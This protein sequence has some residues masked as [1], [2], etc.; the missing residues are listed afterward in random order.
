MRE[1]LKDKITNDLMETYKASDVRDALVRM[2]MDTYDFMAGKI[3]AKFP[4]PS[5]MD[6]IRAHTCNLGKAYG[7][8]GVILFVSAASCG[9]G[10][11]ASDCMEYI[12]KDGTFRPEDV[13][14]VVTDMFKY[15]AGSIRCPDAEISS[16]P[17]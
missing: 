13:E 14:K 16:A 9:L 4:N 8:N 12:W 7:V 10:I 15:Y 17:L 3:A 2:S 11:T 6:F 5:D 1:E